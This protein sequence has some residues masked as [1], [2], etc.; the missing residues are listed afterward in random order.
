[1]VIAARIVDALDRLA[2]AQRSFR[3]V[4]ASREGLTVLQADLLRRIAAGPPPDPVVGLLARDLG[5]TQPTATGAIDALEAKHLVRRHADPTDRRRSTIRLTQRGSRLARRLTQDDDVLLG[6]LS[7]MPDQDQ[8]QTLLAL[9]GVIRQFVDA[10]IIT[11]SRTCLTCRFHEI[12][13]ATGTHRCQ[14][15][16]EDLPVASL[17]VNC[18][19]H[20]PVALHAR[21]A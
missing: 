2:R 12:E 21:P 20:Q 6:A 7:A 10:G 18:A 8:E 13:A 14:L 19:E 9:L 1:V 5:V 15:L 16:G 4:A 3:Q 11:V 17:R